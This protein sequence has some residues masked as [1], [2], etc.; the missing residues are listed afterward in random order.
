MLKK[1]RIIVSSDEE[2]DGEEKRNHKRVCLTKPMEES[3]STDSKNIKLSAPETKPVEKL[4]RKSQVVENPV[5]TLVLLVK[6][7]KRP[8]GCPQLSVA[9]GSLYQSCLHVVRKPNFTTISSAMVEHVFKYVD[10]Y[11]FLGCLCRVLKDERREVTFRVSSRMTSRAGQLSTDARCSRLHELSIS[12][13]LLF[14]A[15]TA[16]SGQAADRAITVNGVSCSSRL[17]C[18]LRI[19]EHEAVHLLLT[20]PSI[21]RALLGSKAVGK[22]DE[23]LTG[24]DM[25]GEGFHGGTFQKAACQ[26][27]GHSA[28]QH[29]LVTTHEI[30]YTEHGICVGA[31]VTF[32]VAGEGTLKGKVN[33]VQKRVTVLVKER[34][35]SRPHGDAREFSD[36]NFY[37]KFYVPIEQCK[38]VK[39]K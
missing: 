38:V 7:G 18:L 17:D 33:R 32:N 36:G 29:D 12:S 15:F 24:G 5:T 3:P 30:A 2:S 22:S 31:T 27:C 35:S 23:E 6:S 19:V 8:P 14:Q 9:L 34:D 4:S 39:N 11:L 37:R 1:R 13:H 10:K 16:S 21:C 28:W 25:C 26:I 20:C